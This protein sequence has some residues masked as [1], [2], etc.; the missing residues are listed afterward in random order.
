M[1]IARAME[2]HCDFPTRIQQSPLWKKHLLQ[3][4]HIYDTSEFET[5]LIN[6]ESKFIVVSD[7]GLRE[8]KGSFGVAFGTFSSDIAMIE[9]PAPGNSLL[10]TSLRSKAYGL[11]AG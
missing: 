1:P 4:F 11:L 10:I 7:G 9:G 5:S 8:G 6:I 3:Y 2:V